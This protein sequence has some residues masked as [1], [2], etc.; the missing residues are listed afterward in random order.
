[1]S[2]AWS[3]PHAT[4]QVNLRAEPDDAG[5][6][7]FIEVLTIP[8]LRRLVTLTGAAENGPAFALYRARGFEADERAS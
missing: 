5:C 7:C 2:V 8:E 1:V 3:T 4:G 6:P